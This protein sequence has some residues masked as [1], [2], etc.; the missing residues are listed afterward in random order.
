MSVMLELRR[1]AYLHEDGAPNDT[2]IDRFAT[3]AARFIDEWN[4]DRRAT[5]SESN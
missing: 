4:P 1:D 3:C 5:P 2:A